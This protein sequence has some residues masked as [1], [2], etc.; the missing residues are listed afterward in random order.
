MVLVSRENKRR[1]FEYLL[2]EGVIVVKKDSYLPFHQQLTEV[3]NLQVMM[4]VKSLKSKGY[5]Q[6]VYNWQWCY[7]FITTK[8]VNFLVKKLGNYLFSPLVNLSSLQASPRTSFPLLSRRAEPLRY[9]RLREKMATMR[10]SADPKEKR[11]P[12]ALEEDRDDQQPARFVLIPK[13]INAN[14]LPRSILSLPIY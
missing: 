5:L 13:D 4:M 9:R 2:R 6:D 7:Y 1:V 10:R 3:P 14:I 12:P 11:E 8:G